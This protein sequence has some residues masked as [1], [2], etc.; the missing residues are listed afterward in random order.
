[1]SV[2]VYYPNRDSILNQFE[3]ENNNLKD[4]FHKY[5]FIRS[6]VFPK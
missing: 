5:K 1:M 4:N 2:D 3:F 6:L